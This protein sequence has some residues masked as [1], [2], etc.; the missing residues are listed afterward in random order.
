MTRNPLELAD[1]VQCH[2]CPTLG[3]NH[4]P[5]VGRVNCRL[6]IVGQ[7]PG[8]KEVEERQPFVGPCG[9]M[10]DYMLDEACLTRDDV[11]IAN[12]LKCRPPGNR[13]GTA[14]EL[15]TCFKTW[16][17]YEIKL[18][19]APLVLLLG[20]DAATTV[21]PDGFEFKHGALYQGKTKRFLVSYHPSYFLR[22]GEEEEFVKIG[23]TIRKLLEGGHENR[24]TET[25]SG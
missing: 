16:L 8:A 9:E 11:Y 23:E 20:K 24:N 17:R 1:V 22:R 25:G 5:S 18:V 19:E 12:A 14:E 7:S 15:S 2:A 13:P 4:V 10:L 21:L 3:D 6:M